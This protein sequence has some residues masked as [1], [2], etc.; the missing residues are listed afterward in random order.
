MAPDDDRL[1]TT[2][3]V[4]RE[5]RSVST[6]DDGMCGFRIFLHNLEITCT[7]IHLL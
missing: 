3:I 5:I 2:N 4:Q 7:D 1:N 6:V